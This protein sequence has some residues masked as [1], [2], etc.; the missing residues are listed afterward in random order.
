MSKFFSEFQIAKSLSINYSKQG[1]WGIFA[2][3]PQWLERINIPYKE[4][5]LIK[6]LT[7]NPAPHKFKTKT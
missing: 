3:F 5:S 7:Y 6:K 2:I 1:R 4:E